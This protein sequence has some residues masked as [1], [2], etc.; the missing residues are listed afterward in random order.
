MQM[1]KYGRKFESLRVSLTQACN[2]SCVYCVPNNLLLKKLPDELHAEQIMHLIQ[3]ISQCIHIKK[4]RITG[5]EPLLYKEFHKL[6]DFFA[7]SSFKNISLTTNGVLVGKNIDAIIRAGIKTVNM[8][9]DTIQRSTFHQMTRRDSLKRTLQGIDILQEMGIKIKVNMVPMKINKQD[10]VPLLEYC[11]ERNIECRYIELMKMG[12]V[13]E[14]FE[15]NFVSMQEILNIIGATYSF[16]PIK[17]SLDSTAT[18]FQI[19]DSQTFGIIPNESQ[20]FCHNCNRLRL[21]SSGKLFGC[22][23]NSKN[24]SLRQFLDVPPPQAAPQ[25]KSILEEAMLSK[26]TAFNGSSVFMQEIGG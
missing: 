1:D 9:L 15:E 20:P 5:G 18:R 26:Q 19:K 3:C 17:S 24:F 8:S 6:A 21:T 14:I 22:I 13:K 12:H 4:I 16:K 7:V 2:F 11:M 23:S 25:I 10:I